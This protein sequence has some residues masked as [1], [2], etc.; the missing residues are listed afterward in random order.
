MAVAAAEGVEGYGLRDVGWSVV[1]VVSYE[2]INDVLG[3]QPNEAYIGRIE[4]H[5]TYV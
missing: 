1:Q 2:K 3:H 4:W 5:D